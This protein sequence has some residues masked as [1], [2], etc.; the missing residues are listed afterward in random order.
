MDPEAISEA[1]THLPTIVQA[2]LGTLPAWLVPGARKAVSR[3]IGSAVEIPAT[4]LDQQAAAIRAKGEAKAEVEKSV[5]G[6][7]VSYIASDNGMGQR[8]AERL[9]AKEYRRQSN[10]EAVA[11]AALEDL[12]SN[13]TQTA[14][15]P[16]VAPN[17]DEDWL[18][19]FERF[20]E[21]ASTERMQNLWGRVLAGEIRQP[22][23]FALRTLRFLSEF[24]QAEALI[25]SSLCENAFGE[26]APVSLIK[27]PE[28]RDQRHL[29]N[30]ETCGLIA[31]ATSRELSLSFDCKKGSPMFF[32]ERDLYIRLICDQ[33]IRH[34]I[35]VVSLTP[36]GQDLISLLPGRDAKAAARKVAMAIRAPVFKAAYLGTVS[37]SANA[38]PMEVLWQEDTPP[39][40]VPT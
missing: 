24:S 13:Q 33:D 19:V 17:V 29:I 27:I 18:N 7:A 10:T 16:V 38:V 12:R 23:R 1:I 31:G 4:W 14:E 8:A 34:A 22:G 32:R 15:S 11:V 30:M 9:V 39:N 5:V 36:L 6:Q 2:G 35:R 28:Q 3:L 21:D 40:A 25:F 20:A 37:A 26:F